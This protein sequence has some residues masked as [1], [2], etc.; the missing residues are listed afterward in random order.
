MT[1]LWSLGTISEGLFMAEL[2][3]QGMI[4]FFP[5]VLIVSLQWERS[6]FSFSN[7]KK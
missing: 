7:K 2:E 1:S 3:F 4:I 5:E 6:L